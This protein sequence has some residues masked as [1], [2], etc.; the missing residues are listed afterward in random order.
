[1][2]NVDREF[3]N[4][5]VVPESEYIALRVTSGVERYAEVSHCEYQ[6][7]AGSEKD[8]LLPL[9][10]LMAPEANDYILQC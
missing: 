6:V 8:G 9:Y 5:R 7:E 4:G 1:M 10:S 2:D 3:N